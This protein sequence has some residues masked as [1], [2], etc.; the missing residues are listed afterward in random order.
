MKCNVGT[1]S[2]ATSSLNIHLVSNISVA[3]CYQAFPIYPPPLSKEEV[4]HKLT[5]QIVAPLCK[6]SHMFGVGVGNGGN[7]DLHFDSWLRMEDNRCA[8]H[9]KDD[10]A[11]QQSAA[12]VRA[13]NECS[14]KRLIA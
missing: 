3:Q 1:I 13:I 6:E 5:N 4:A 9:L 14:Q 10:L 8:R 11:D 2:S 12:K 7:H